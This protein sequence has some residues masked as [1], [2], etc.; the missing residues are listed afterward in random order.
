LSTSTESAWSRPQQR[1][2]GVDMASTLSAPSPGH[3]PLRS[4]SK[5]PQQSKSLRTRRSNQQSNNDYSLRSPLQLGE[6]PTL[7]STTSTS[8]LV[9]PATTTSHKPRTRASASLFT[10]A[11][12]PA[13]ESVTLQ[14]TAL[15]SAERGWTRR[16]AET[17]G[18]LLDQD[19]RSKF[20]GWV[21]RAEGAGVE[22]AAPL[23]S[24]RGPGPA[25]AWA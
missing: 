11:S 13:S 25:W 12:T 24:E 9:P 20:C 1:D 3:S 23:L 15:P 10:S 5:S 14:S 19:D 18:R 8:S 22:V 7:R 17:A 2:L 16:W 4:P 21:G 6:G